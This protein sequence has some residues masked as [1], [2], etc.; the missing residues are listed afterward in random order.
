MS[1][2]TL[3]PPFVVDGPLPVAP[4]YGLL[5]A[6]KILPPSADPHWMI[7]AEVHSYSP[8]MPYGW[9]P[10]LE[11]STADTKYDGSDDT[12]PMP[13]F[14]PFAVYVAVDCSTFTGRPD[15]E[16]RQ[17]IAAVFEAKEGFAV[18]QQLVA[19]TWQPENPYMAKSGQAEVLSSAAVKPTEALAL[20]ETAIALKAE[21]GMIHATPGIA[22]AWQDRYLI[23]DV[24]GVMRTQAMGTPVAIG[25]GYIGQRPAGKAPSTA[26]GTKE[27]A[28]ATG[29]IEIRRTGMEILAPTLKESL[30]RAHNEIVERPERYYLVIW[31]TK[32]T[33]AVNV[34]RAL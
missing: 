31:D 23:E 18:E 26:T 8:T 25:G 7:G 33:A 24:G 4:K 14:G 19:G 34:D 11:G 16:L 6:A 22:T 17:R 32:L 27:W 13:E 20:L 21:G 1:Q 28:W 15:E 30:D 2:A 3:G 29:P 9:A 5:A 12:I 10:C